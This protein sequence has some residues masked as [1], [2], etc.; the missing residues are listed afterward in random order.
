[1]SA[2]KHI[3][4]NVYWSYGTHIL[5][6]SINKSPATEV[7]PGWLES[8]P[9]EMHFTAKLCNWDGQFTDQAIH[10]SLPLR[11]E[12]QSIQTW[13]WP[14]GSQSPGHVVN[15]LWVMFILCN[16]D[17]QSSMGCKM[18]QLHDW[19]FWVWWAKINK[20]CRRCTRTL[21]IIQRTNP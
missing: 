10:R 8:K 18:Y 2:E 17:D 21:L 12:Q 16:Q 1:M 11:F 4:L 6:L 3:S 7:G 14:E 5:I 20:T 15:M 19:W 9:Q 13:C